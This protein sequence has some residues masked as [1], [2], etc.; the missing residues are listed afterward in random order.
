MMS[1]RAG[2]MRLPTVAIKNRHLWS[3]RVSHGCPPHGTHGV[4]SR[5]SPAIFGCLGTNEHAASL[6]SHAHMF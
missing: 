1:Q 4:F 2:A 5:V 6:H 3:A